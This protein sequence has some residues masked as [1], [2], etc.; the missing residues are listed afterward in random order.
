MVQC[1]SPIS[2]PLATL[3]SL[4][5]QAFWLSEANPDPNFQCTLKLRLMSSSKTG[6]PHEKDVEVTMLVQCH[7]SLDIPLVEQLSL[8]LQALWLFEPYPIHNSN[9]NLNSIAKKRLTS[10]SQMSVPQKKGVEGG[11][12]VQCCTPFSC[13]QQSQYPYICRLFC[14][15]DANPNPNLRGILDLRLTSSS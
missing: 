10:F 3:V 2:M 5:L 6:V 12:S 1:H 8:E 11:T 9:T 14:S 4:I 13:H 15:L 7:A